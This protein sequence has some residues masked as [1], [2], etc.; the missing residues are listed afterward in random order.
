M[1]DNLDS[2]TLFVVSELFYPEDTSTG[3]FVTKIAEGLAEQN[4]VKA[5][6]SKPTYSE[7][8]LEVPSREV[9]NGVDIH[10]VLS[11]RMNK[12][13]LIGRFLNLL[14]FSLAAA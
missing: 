10:R 12:D 11:T 8:H 5:I 2:R 7:R 13:K 9:H 4:S 14:T 6:C 1:N 3:Y